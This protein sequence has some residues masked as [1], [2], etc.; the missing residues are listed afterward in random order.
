VALNRTS[1]FELGCPEL[2]LVSLDWERR[3]LGGI[4]MREGIQEKKALSSKSSPRSNR[5]VP[6][7]EI[8]FVCCLQSIG[9]LNLKGRGVGKSN[10]RLPRTAGV[11]KR[12]RPLEMDQVDRMTLSRSQWHD[13]Q[14]LNLPRLALN[15]LP[16]P[17]LTILLSPTTLST[18]KTRSAATRSNRQSQVDKD[19]LAHFLTQMSTKRTLRCCHYTR[20]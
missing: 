16:A 17:W 8:A 15:S 4:Q 12:W 3:W 20:R 7:Q 13:P 6:G 18:T 2:V 9:V 11:F 19:L 5:C 14:T 1:E 10:R